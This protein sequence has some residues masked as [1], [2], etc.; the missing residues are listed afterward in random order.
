MIERVGF[1]QFVD[2]CSKL[3]MKSAEADEVWY[4][5]FKDAKTGEMKVLHHGPAL[6]DPDVARL[7]AKDFECLSFYLALLIEDRLEVEAY[8]NNVLS[9]SVQFQVAK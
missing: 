4:P 9:H 6:A 1:D 3:V 5:T 7:W 2:L 8:D